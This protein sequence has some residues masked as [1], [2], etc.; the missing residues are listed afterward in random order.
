MQVEEGFGVKIIRVQ[1]VRFLPHLFQLI[2]TAL[3]KTKTNTLNI[4]DRKGLR[5][6]RDANYVQDD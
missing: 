4:L 5:G 1:T 2:L 6:S 3:I